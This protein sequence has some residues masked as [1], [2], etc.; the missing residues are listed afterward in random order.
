MGNLDWPKFRRFWFPVILYSGIIF[1]VSSVPYVRTPL[2]EVQFDKIMHIL[3]YIPFGFLVARG[4]W[5]AK[6]SI[7]GK[8]LLTAVFL[9]SFLFSAGDEFHQAFFESAD[10]FLFHDKAKNVVYLVEAYAYSLLRDKH[11]VDVVVA[12]GGVG[13]CPHPLAFFIKTP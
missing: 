6:G 9:V 8:T 2:Q 5:N 12:G 7:S 3:E 4:L 10:G 11:S 1:Y 13:T